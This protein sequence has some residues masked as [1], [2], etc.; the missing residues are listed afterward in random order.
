MYMID[1]FSYRTSQEG[2]NS[3]IRFLVMHYT[4]V[5]F[6]ISISALTGKSVSTHYLVPNPNDKTYVGAGFNDVRIFNLVDEQ[7]RAWHA[8]ISSWSGRDNLNDTSIGIEI[9]NE[10]SYSEGKFI[11]PAYDFSQIEAVKQ[12]AVDIL[13]RYPNISPRNVVG[14]SDISIGRKSD[15]G[16]VFPWY[17]LYKSGV[18]AWFDDVTKNK[19]LEK[20]SSI[21]PPKD[22]VIQMLN[23]YGYSVSNAN[24]K[25]R[26]F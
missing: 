11:F 5:N 1:N 2:Y 3:R 6:D 22:E 17:E 14:H 21:P 13:K 8:G 4:A 20:F 12:L 19:Y 23:K 10:A 9:V 16:A 15:P 25:K 7:E 18:G 24:D 26:V